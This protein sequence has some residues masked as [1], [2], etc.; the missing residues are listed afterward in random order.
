MNLDRLPAD[1]GPAGRHVI[2]EAFEDNVRD[3]GEESLGFGE[4]TKANLFISWQ[5]TLRW[6]EFLHGDGYNSYF[7]D[8]KIVISG[9]C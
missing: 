1:Q 9:K 7:L 6:L 8:G 5:S 4:N 2:H 3:F